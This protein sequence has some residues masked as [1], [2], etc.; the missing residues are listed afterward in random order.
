[1]KT[2]T[3]FFF[4]WEKKKEH[5]CSNEIWAI[6][7]RDNVK[8]HREE[9]NWFSFSRWSPCPS[10]ASMP[11]NLKAIVFLRKHH[12]QLCLVLYDCHAHTGPLNW[13]VCA[14]TQL[15]IARYIYI[16]Y[17]LKGTTSLM[18][19]FFLHFFKLK[20]KHLFKSNTISTALAYKIS[21]FL[22]IILM[23]L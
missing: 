10:K 16:F 2:L 20:L 7:A 15:K 11:I 21:Y 1:M 13:I 9:K 19:E 6:L 23:T 12:F 4:F 17:F 3:P 5:T 18:A 22:S 8:A 14:C